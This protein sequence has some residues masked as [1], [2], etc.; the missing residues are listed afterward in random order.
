M[1]AIRSYYGLEKKEFLDPDGNLTVREGD[2]VQSYFLGTKNNE[3]WFAT[4]ISGE[5]VGQ[6]RMEDAFRNGIPVEGNR[7]TSYNV[8][9]TKLLRD[10]RSGDR[11]FSRPDRQEQGNRPTVYRIIFERNV[12]KGRGNS[13]TKVRGSNRGPS[14]TPDGRW[15]KKEYLRWERFHHHFL[16]VLWPGWHFPCSAERSFSYNFV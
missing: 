5:A 6:S 16:S 15:F 9:Y 10:P 11:L 14:L 7:I 12:R 13:R 1:Y 4:K 3:M 8:C 2:T